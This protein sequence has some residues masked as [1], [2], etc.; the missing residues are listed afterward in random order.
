MAKE[1]RRVGSNLVWETQEE[2]TERRAFNFFFFFF[3]LSF[4][5]LFS[6][7]FLSFISALL[8]S[9]LLRFQVL[10]TLLYDDRSLSLSFP[11]FVSR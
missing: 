4:F 1:G 5:P 11:S 6:S 8:L 9:Y 7:S 2:R 3:F 10:L